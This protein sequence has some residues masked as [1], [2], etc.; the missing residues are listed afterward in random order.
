MY[1][2]SLPFSK[3]ATHSN[4]CNGAGNSKLAVTLLSA[5]KEV[6]SVPYF[7]EFNPVLFLFPL[8]RGIQF[9]TIIFSLQLFSFSVSNIHK[10]TVSLIHEKKQAILLP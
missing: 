6:H 1:L 7:I 3:K 9:N 10:E 8:E 5:R 4:F 2:S